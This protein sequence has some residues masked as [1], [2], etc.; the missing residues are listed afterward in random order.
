MQLQK[1]QKWEM[2]KNMLPFK[3]K[4]KKT[5]QTRD[6]LDKNDVWKKNTWADSK[7]MQTTSAKKSKQNANQTRDQLD[8]HDFE[9]ENAKKTRS[10][11]RKCETNMPTAPL[12]LHLSCICDSHVCCIVLLHLHF[13]ALH[14]FLVLNLGNEGMIQKKKNDTPME[15][16]M[17]LREDHEDHSHSHPHPLHS[18]PVRWCTCFP[19][20]QFSRI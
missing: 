14:G 4:K 19:K 5:I 15:R 8:K 3:K 12:H 7:K 16:Q 13:L 10:N 2:E 18:S 6:Q 17:R 20:L 1:M 11:G 9:K